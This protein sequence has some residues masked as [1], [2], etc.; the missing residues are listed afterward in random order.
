MPI[1]K[2]WGYQHIDGSIFLRYYFSASEYEEAQES[3]FVKVVIKPF[4][5][6]NRKHAEARLREKLMTVRPTGECSA[7]GKPK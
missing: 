7:M 3:E 2:Y 6:I 1:A 4:K 5:A